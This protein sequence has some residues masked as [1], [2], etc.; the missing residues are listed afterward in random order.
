MKGTLWYSALAQATHVTTTPV[1]QVA[2]DGHC[3]GARLVSAAD[4]STH[5]PP[6][7][8]QVASTAERD[9]ALEILWPRE[10]FVGVRW[11]IDDLDDA[12]A[13]SARASEVV[14]D[15]ARVITSTA[16]ARGLD[17]A[18]LALVGATP[19]PDLEF[20]ELG[21][22]NA[23]GSIGPARLWTRGAPYSPAATEALLA[24]RPDLTS[25]AHPLAVE[26]AATRLRPCWIGIIVSSNSSDNHHLDRP[27]LNRVL[28]NCI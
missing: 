28:N 10:A 5:T 15:Q 13:A 19:S 6:T 17:A 12:Q 14:G 26:V 7:L 24:R 3:E 27:A 16:T 23:W 21:A 20:A 25:C 9:I 8:E 1:L 2:A 18:L 11:P 4:I 22:V